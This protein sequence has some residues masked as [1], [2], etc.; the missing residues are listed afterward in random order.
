[1]TIY[2]NGLNKRP[3]WAG[4]KDHETKDLPFVY[5]E[6]AYNYFLDQHITIVWFSF[7]IA[8]VS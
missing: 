4:N 1:M 3:K 7:S 2:C 6:W 8:T 5:K